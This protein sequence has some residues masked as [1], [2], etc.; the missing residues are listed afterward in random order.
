VFTDCS[1]PASWGSSRISTKIVIPR[2]SRICT[3]PD[4]ASP[5]RVSSGELQSPM[6]PPVQPPRVGP[7]LPSEVSPADHRRSAWASF[8]GT[9]I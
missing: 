6:L 5:C 4:M 7:D 9:R 2:E 8:S 3:A 1:S